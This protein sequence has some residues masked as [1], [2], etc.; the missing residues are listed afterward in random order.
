MKEG[1]RRAANIISREIET[2]GCDVAV[3]ESCKAKHNSKVSILTAAEQLTIEN[4]N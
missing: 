3:C 4:E 2:A 1:M